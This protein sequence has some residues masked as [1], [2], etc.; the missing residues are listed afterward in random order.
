MPTQ[1]EVKKF[2]HD[3]GLKVNSQ[4]R[5]REIWNPVSRN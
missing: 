5:Q 4:N 3:S 1:S 2:T